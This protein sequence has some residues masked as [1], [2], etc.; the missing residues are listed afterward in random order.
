MHIQT[1]ESL[2]NRQTELQSISTFILSLNLL[3][4]AFYFRVGILAKNIRNK[5]QI[6][7]SAFVFFGSVQYILLVFLVGFS[8]KFLYL[9]FML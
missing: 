2:H 1:N 7:I 3:Y 6:E 5:L 9:L 8:I 4:L